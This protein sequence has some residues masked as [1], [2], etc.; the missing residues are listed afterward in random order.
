MTR[1]LAKLIEVFLLLSVSS[2]CLGE[3][4]LKQCKYPLVPVSTSVASGHRG[5]TQ[6]PPERFISVPPF[7]PTGP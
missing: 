1:N 4:A 7:G 2:K 6:W 3:G 5:H